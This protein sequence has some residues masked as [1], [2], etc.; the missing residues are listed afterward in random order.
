MSTSDPNLSVLLLLCSV[1]ILPCLS[2]SADIGLGPSHSSRS[3]STSETVAK[4]TDELSDTGISVVAPRA[5]VEEDCLTNEDNPHPSTSLARF[6]RPSHTS[7]GVQCT[8]TL[9]F[10]HSLEKDRSR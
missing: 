5:E 1:T 2:M 3:E 7:D 10:D 4:S 9:E 8:S 6:I